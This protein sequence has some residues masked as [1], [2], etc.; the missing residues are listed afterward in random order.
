MGASSSGA[1]AGLELGEGSRDERAHHPSKTNGMM[2][3]LLPAV[4]KW[5]YD[6]QT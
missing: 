6:L 3:S 2:G 4:A 1:S 5:R